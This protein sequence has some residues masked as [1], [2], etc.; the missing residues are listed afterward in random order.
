MS[1]VERWFEEHG[2]DNPCVALDPRACRRQRALCYTRARR[3]GRGGSRICAIRPAVN[4]VR[5]SQPAL[6]ALGARAAAVLER[7]DST[8]AEVR[9]VVAP[10]IGA[11]CGRPAIWRVPPG[12]PPV[13][14]GSSGDVLPICRRARRLPDALVPEDCEHFVL[15]EGVEPTEVAVAAAMGALGV[16]PRIWDAWRCGPGDVRMVETRVRGQTLRQWVDAL[17]AAL[18]EGG[19]REALRAEFW[20]VVDAVLCA[21]KRMHDAGVLHDDLNENNVLLEWEE[22]GSQGDASRR[23]RAWLLDFAHARLRHRLDR[24]ARVGNLAYLMGVLLSL[25]PPLEGRLVYQFFADREW[26]PRYEACSTHTS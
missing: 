4:R 19:D 16:G 9:S 2:L 22:G 24:D 15:K 6:A 25:L 11:R 23:V 8:L 1:R 12:Q 7:P 21:A 10:A 17:D 18:A 26:W 20:A 5:L 13:G 14:R 3:R